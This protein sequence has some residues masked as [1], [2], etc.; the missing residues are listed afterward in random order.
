MTKKF[1]LKQIETIDITI[2]FFDS[3]LKTL[4]D[5]YYKTDMTENQ[6]RLRE[7]IKDF[8]VTKK[9]LEDILSYGI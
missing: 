2:A 7:Q 4:T 9:H 3:C 5:R 6:R 8:E 1:I